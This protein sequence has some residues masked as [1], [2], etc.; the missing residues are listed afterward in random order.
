MLNKRKPTT[1]K[2]YLT[3]NIAQVRNFQNK[4]TSDQSLNLQTDE[5]KTRYTSSHTK[6]HTTKIKFNTRNKEN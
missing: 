5:K 2:Q 4:S 1:I 3:N 6:Q